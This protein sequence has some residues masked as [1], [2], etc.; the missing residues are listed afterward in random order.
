[1]ED[2]ILKEQVAFYQVVNTGGMCDIAVD[3]TDG[4]FACGNDGA[5]HCFK[6][7]REDD[8][9]LYEHPTELRC[10]AIQGDSLLV[11][12]IDGKVCHIDLI[13]RAFIEF[14][15]RLN[16]PIRHLSFSPDGSRFVVAS[17]ENKVSIRPLATD[18]AVVYALGHSAPVLCAEFD[19]EG[20]YIATASTD[21]TVRV[22]RAVSGE[23]VQVI[24]IPHA[25][26]E[27]RLQVAWTMDGGELAVPQGADIAM[28]QRNSWTPLAPFKSAHTK[29]V[30]VMSFRRDGDMLATSGLDKMLVLWAVTSRT[31]LRRFQHEEIISGLSWKPNHTLAIIDTSGEWSVLE[32]LPSIPAHEIT[33]VAPAATETKTSSDETGS[34][35]HRRVVS[36]VDDE[37]MEGGSDESEDDGAGSEMPVRKSLSSKRKAR[38]SIHSDD[39]DDLL[40]GFI[41][42]GDDDFAGDDWASAKAKPGAKATA[43]PV[44]LPAVN[45]MQAPVQ[46]GATEMKDGRR[47]LAWNMTAVVTARDERTHVV[48]EVEFFDKARRRVV[49]SDV[50]QLSMAALSD[51]GCFFAG[52]E[53]LLFNNFRAAFG[54][55]NQWSLDLPKGEE[56]VSVAASTTFVCVATTA[57]YLRAFTCSG[58]QLSI[59]ALPG[60]I[61]AM[62]AHERSLRIVY[63]GAPA[64]GAQQFFRMQTIN[65]YSRL[66]SSPVVVSDAAFALSPQ[67]KLIWIGFA[68]SG[69]LHVADSASILWRA[70]TDGRFEPILDMNSTTKDHKRHWVVD[71]QDN[72][73]MSVL[74]KGDREP[75]TLPRPLLDVTPLAMPLLTSQDME[76]DQIVLA[77]TE[78]V[79]L[80]RCFDKLLKANK[81][82]RAIDV[83]ALLSQRESLAVGVKLAAAKKLFDVVDQLQAL[84]QAR[85]AEQEIDEFLTPEPVRS[86]SALQHEPT[87][88]IRREEPAPRRSTILVDEDPEEETQ[89][90]EEE[91][92][93]TNDDLDND[94]NAD[95]AEQTPPQAAPRKFNR[96]CCCTDCLLVSHSPCSCYCL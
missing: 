28:Y 75:A 36:F 55:S 73:L 15:V 20:E 94:N 88:T 48:M 31:A 53:S 27:H 96:M 10:I 67:S 12:A 82:A 24:K 37:A 83:A 39:E 79:P 92:A 86:R 66:S 32:K 77:E 85:A 76:T 2:A 25:N 90:G 44:Y 11:G 51:V 52:K 14:P 18:A 49:I 64:Q 93:E 61:V 4:V 68:E 47:Y 5:L 30:T 89:G 65:I 54:V 58:V 87:V 63:H 21:G 71:V 81:T 95:E 56:A 45:T 19:P 1:M 38:H 91:Y 84:M 16:L 43:A 33:P 9:V 69:T 29:P 42:D 6:N 57:G 17:E 72:Q 35:G 40:G 59:T 41:V 78:D 74:L 23:P 34:S 46:P 22:F 62:V 70:R 8:E 60:P 7:G 80:L 26:T 13:Q 3:V 50:K